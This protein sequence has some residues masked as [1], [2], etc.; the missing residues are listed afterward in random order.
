MND[1]ALLIRWPNHLGDAL[2][3]LPALS[4]LVEA[5]RAPTLVGKGW[6]RALLAAYPWPVHAVAPTLRAAAAQWRRLRAEAGTR[7]ALIF[8]NSF[9][10]AL[11]A[12]LGGA[13]ATGYATDGR[14]WLLARAVPVPARWRGDMHTVEYYDA[15][16]AAFLGTTARPVPPL[17]LR[18]EART[19]DAARALLD[20]AA[21]RAPYVVLC[22]GATGLHRGRAKTWGDFDRLT[23]WLLDRGERVVALPGPG[24]RARFE[25]ALPGATLLPE[26]DVAT[27]GALLAAS[28][29]VVANDSGPGHLAAAVGARLVS[30]FG[31]TEV[32]KTRPWGHRVTL[33]GSD[34]GWPS[35]DDVVS[36]VDAALDDAPH[37]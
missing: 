22:P 13:A 3:T 32:E 29:L 23:R 5:G 34:A 7:Q 8:T 28:R 19:H 20:G 24:E 12:R 26:A 2:M 6:A 35:F 18:L 9:S 25:A 31:V 1:A 14:G 37:G 4:R 11:A 27:F 21:V 33:M 10:T 16:A 15:L 17:E 36:A 30:L